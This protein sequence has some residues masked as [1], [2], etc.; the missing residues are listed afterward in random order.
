MWLEPSHE[1]PRR[2]HLS[3]RSA[4]RRW[5]PAQLA[6]TIRSPAP[7]PGHPAGDGR[8]CTPSA[9]ALA[10][11]HP[12]TSDHPYVPQER[13]REP[14]QT[15]GPRRQHTC[16]RRRAHPL[17][18]APS[19]SAAPADTTSYTSELFLQSALGLPEKSDH[20]IESITYDRFQWLLQ[21]PGRFAFLIGDPATD[22]TFAARAQDVEE[23]ATAAG[24][25]TVYWF[26]PNLSG[27]VKVGAIT[28]P[29]LD[30]RNPA[31]ITS[32]GSTSQQI[33]GYAWTNLI[34]RYLGNG[35]KVTQVN[36]ANTGSAKVTTSFDNTVVNDAGATAGSS[37]K[38]GNTSGGALY[39]YSSGSAPATV[40]DSYFFVYDK[41]RTVTPSGA[42]AAQAAKIVSWVDV[43]KE[44]SSAATK[45]DVTTAISS[46]GAATIKDLSEYA[47][48]KSATNTWQ[49]TSSPNEYQ[50][51]NVPV[52]TD[53]DG[54][55]RRVAGVSIRSRTPS[56]STS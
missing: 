11:P 47:W 13:T 6:P 48:W 39:D 25:K 46:A 31:G 36:P 21:Q 41:D 53:A 51:S 45:T 5:R 43:T 52:I 54:D 30:I 32:I 23:A 35:I 19:A 44:G 40:Q 37:T 1:L 2:L 4:A 27:N 20:T 34:G 17:I 16:R 38:V 15:R 49:S 18:S 50:G 10:G 28:E 3:R 14:V 56:S 7:R 9:G 26:D 55:R 22:A 12:P 29:N 33:F 24:V 42:P 8:W